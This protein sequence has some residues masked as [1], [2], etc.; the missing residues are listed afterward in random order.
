M[1]SDRWARVE[2]LYHAALAHDAGERAAFLR[3]ACADD[4]SLRGDV[5]SLL[6]QP[7]SGDF[8]AAPAMALAAELVSRS[9][10]RLLSGRRFGVYQILGLLGAGGMGEVY[11]A[12]DTR[13]GRD[14]AIKI[15]PRAFTAHPDRLA[16]FE[17]EARVLASLNHPHIAAIHG[18]EDAS[19]DAGQPVRALILELAEGETLAERIA[20][21][22]TKGVPL[23]EALDIARQIADALD[24]AHQKGIVHRD[25]KPA[26]IKITPQGVV[27]VLD[28]GLAKLEAVGAGEEFTDAPTLTVNDTREGLV[29]GTAAYMS[30]EQAR[31]KATDKRTDVWAFGCVLY[32]MLTGCRAFPAETAT[33]ILAAILERKVDWT[34][35]PSSTPSNVRSVL[36]RTLEKDPRRRLHDIADARIELEDELPAEPSPPKTDW[37]RTT[38]GWAVGVGVAMAAFALGQWYVR[39]A[40][41]ADGARAGLARLLVAPEAPLVAASEGL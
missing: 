20:R 13:L 10:T 1:T 22:G 19:I 29:I 16:R 26:N 8:V 7:V 6:A 25:L 32:E 24:A 23:T 38:F 33:E 35:L 18:I 41:P 37:R 4:D 30:P 27:K 11:R 36:R 28:F 40:V 21:A 34:K 17:R 5:E 31:G 12:R 39:V 9:E 14:V 2:R 15:L 3:E